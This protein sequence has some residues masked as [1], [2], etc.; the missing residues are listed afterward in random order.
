MIAVR[1]RP[2]SSA[3][4]LSESH[5]DRIS[6]RAET[7]ALEYSLRFSRI[8]G[9][10]RHRRLPQS[11]P[12]AALAKR[13]V[14]LPPILSEAAG[15]QQRS[16]QSLAVHQ[17]RRRC[18]NIADSRSHA[19]AGRG[20]H[21]EHVSNTLFEIDHPL[22]AIGSPLRGCYHSDAQARATTAQAHRCYCATSLVPVAGPLVSITN[23]AC[24]MGTF[25][26]PCL[27]DVWTE[28]ILLTKHRAEQCR[29]NWHFSAARPREPRTTGPL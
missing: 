10:R 1:A 4:S 6:L 20:P 16:I 17:C 8:G 14:A 18:G 22:H 7:L 2:R 13:A 29:V 15:K 9:W 21:Q 23:P 19:R 25:R 11:R 26:R 3:A 28:A 24:H 27:P 12:Q 5:C